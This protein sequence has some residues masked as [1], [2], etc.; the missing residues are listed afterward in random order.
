MHAGTTYHCGDL[1]GCCH[2]LATR[3]R[4]GDTGHKLHDDVDLLKDLTHGDHVVTQGFPDVFILRVGSGW[5]VR[6]SGGR[7]Q[8]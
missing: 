1:D 6:C 4:D 8:V 3:R 2:H 7:C 5:V